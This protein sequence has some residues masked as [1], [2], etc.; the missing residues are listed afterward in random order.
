MGN[1]HLDFCKQNEDDVSII[2]HVSATAKTDIIW[3]RVR[4][5]GGIWTAPISLIVG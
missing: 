2:N 4:G 1:I 3:L 5:I